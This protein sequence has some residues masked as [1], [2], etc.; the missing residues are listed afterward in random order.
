[1]PKVIR[2]GAC[3]DQSKNKRSFLFYEKASFITKLAE[4]TWKLGNRLRA[5]LR[6]LS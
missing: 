4:D 3:S 1:M 2:L 6:R 5:F